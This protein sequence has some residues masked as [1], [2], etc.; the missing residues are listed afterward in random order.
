MNLRNP[1]SSLKERLKDMLVE[2]GRFVR[3]DYWAIAMYRGPSPLA[4]APAEG[5]PL[6]VLGARDV[7][8]AD[9]EFVADPFMVAAP[10]GGW[11]LFFEVMN[12]STGLGEVAVASSPD[13]TTWTYR[14]VV[15]AEPHHLSYPQVFAWDGEYWMVPETSAQRCVMLYRA[16][17]HPT[18]W[19]R[20]GDLLSGLPFNDATL[21]RHD[22]RWWMLTETAEQVRSDTLRLYSAD[23]LRGT[24][25][26]HPASPVV[27]GDA[28]IARPA[29]PVVRY[30][31][32]L[33]RFAQDCA[34]D[35]GKRVRAFEIVELT[36][37]AYHEHPLGVVLE[38]P[39]AGWNDLGMHQVDAHRTAAGDWLAC[40]DGR[41]VPGLRRS[42]VARIA[43]RQRPRTVHRR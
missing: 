1:L 28:T 30:D 27:A 7:T 36:A 14:Q 23:D 37:S 8:D 24:W 35:Y 32:R 19:E 39:A 43:T 6:P 25:A 38:P 12:R 20:A 3:S 41:P 29:G 21:F 18:R 40:V 16:V 9:A 31:G 22:G 5:V 26:E 17:D 15:L 34:T 11:H 2:T 33:V 42:A 13:A 10:D 4:L